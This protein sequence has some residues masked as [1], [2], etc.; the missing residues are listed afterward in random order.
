MAERGGGGRW[1]ADGGRGAGG[2]QV[3]YA[4]VR[5][6]AAWVYVQHGAQKM[7]GVLGGVGPGGATAPFPSLFGWAGVIE[8]V[9]G[10]LILV[11]LATRVAAFLASGEMATAYF[12][13]HAPHGFLFTVQNHGEVPAMLAFVFLYVA[14]IGGGRYSLD[15]LIV[16]ARA[17][18]AFPAP[19]TP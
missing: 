16:R 13:A 7:L 10:A 8:L 3:V 15:T 11:G 2:A 19:Q 18:R 5:V 14:V 9:C 6:V 1:D 12:I 4:C 17:S